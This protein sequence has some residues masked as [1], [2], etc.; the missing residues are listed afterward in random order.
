[1]IHGLATDCSREQHRIARS[2]ILS[3]S[4]SK[5]GVDEIA[6]HIVGSSRGRC[7][8]PRVTLGRNDPTSPA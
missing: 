3:C 1:M 6:A 4:D 5:N 7:I 8:L 2:G